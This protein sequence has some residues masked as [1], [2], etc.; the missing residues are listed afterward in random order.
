MTIFL[1]HRSGPAYYA[2]HI[3]IWTNVLYYTISTFVEI[4]QCS[5]RKKLWDPKIP[6]HCIND[7]HG[8]QVYS[9][10]LNVLSDFSI[11]VLPLPLIWRL[12]MPFLRKLRVTAV[13]SVGLFACITSVV[14]LTYSID[15]LDVPVGNA[16]YLLDMDKIGLW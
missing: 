11:L 12:Q 1:P 4:F 10:S 8:I 5:P 2:I 13:F 14:R 16:T 6:G 9:G 3:L 7:N 15:L